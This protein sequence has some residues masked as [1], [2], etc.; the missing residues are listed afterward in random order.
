MVKANGCSGGCNCFQL[1]DFNDNTKK[2]TVN[3]LI[4]LRIMLSREIAED[5]G[6]YY[7][8]L[9]QL[10][11]M[12]IQRARIK[13]SVNSVNHNNVVSIEVL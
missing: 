8:I 5:G 10:R 13:I 4:M 3:I 7:T 12:V 11:N 2:I 6:L 9:R 1:L